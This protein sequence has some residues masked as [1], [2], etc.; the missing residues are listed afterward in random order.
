MEMSKEQNGFTGLT[1]QD[2]FMKEI[3]LIGI[4]ENLQLSAQEAKSDTQSLLDE[5]PLVLECES[6]DGEK[7]FQVRWL[8]KNN[9]TKDLLWVM[10]QKHNVLLPDFIRQ[11]KAAFFV[12]FV[13]HNSVFFNVDNFGVV[14]VSNIIPNES[15][16]VTFIFWDRQQQNRQ[17]LMLETMRYCIELWNLQRVNLYVP[18][19]AVS[20]LYRFWKMGL[21]LEGV[22][23]NGMYHNAKWTDLYMF[24][25][26][27]TELTDE[28]IANKAL[29]REEHQ[30][31][32]FDEMKHKK[33]GRV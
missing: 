21:M 22:V 17:K 26:L 28:A 27:R 18:R 11:N 25:V 15:A 13:S 8:K 19:F 23:R 16:T 7:T 14:F 32:W 20:A 6:D 2:S 5:G 9:I 1:D 12:T 31:L 33:D 10:L 24:G 30:Q 4:E 29:Q 3:E